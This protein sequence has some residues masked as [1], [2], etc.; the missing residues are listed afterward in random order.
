[1]DEFKP[2]VH[3]F[4]DYFDYATMLLCARIVDVLDLLNNSGKP[5]EEYWF[6]PD[7][8]DGLREMYTRTHFNFDQGG[9]FPEI[10]VVYCTIFTQNAK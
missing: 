8:L 2:V 7:V 4:M 6:W 3:S 9:Y 1:M 10:K 5:M